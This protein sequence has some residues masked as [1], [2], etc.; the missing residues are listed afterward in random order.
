MKAT[1]MLGSPMVHAIL[2]AI[3]AELPPDD[4]VALAADA[5]V[6]RISSDALV[7]GSQAPAVNSIDA[8]YLE[9]QA[10]RDAILA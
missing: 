2:G 5:G 10:A 3:T 1:G 6:L 8:A 9:L 7:R 4:I